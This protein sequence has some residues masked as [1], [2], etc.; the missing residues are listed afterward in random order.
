MSNAPRAAPHCG[1]K[2]GKK[3]APG[4]N[5]DAMR[6]AIA[7]AMAR[8]K[9]EIPHYYLAHDVDVTAS[10]HWLT[11]TNA[12]RLPENRLLMGA[13]ALKAVALA[14]RRY[15][16]F[17]G[18]YRDNK[19]EP[20]PAVHVGV[21]VSIRGGGLAAPALH[22]VD[23]TPLDDL[24]AHMRD[25][26]QRTRA[27]CIRSSE[28]SDA[29]ITVSSLGERGVDALRHHLSAAG[30]D[31]RC[32]QGGGAAL[33]R[34]RRHRA[35]LDCYPHAVGGS[36][37]QRR[38]RGG[39]NSGRDRQAVA[40]A[41]KAMSDID[42]MKV[43]QEEL[44]NIAPEADLTT[45]DPTADLR[46]ALDV[47]SMD[48]LNFIAAIHH[49]LGIDIPEIDYPKLGTLDGAVAYLTAHRKPSRSDKM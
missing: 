29:T 13:L 3:R 18:F 32:W 42:I 34:G 49:R 41:G 36:P 10:E 21:A 31:R 7:A 5:L 15:P 19:F 22:D 26:V 33:G 38:S 6:V 48:F 23:Q 28:L 20:A 25:L 39:A 24:M 40:G 30:G 37:R 43:V 16:A 2:G 12:T 27:G 17:N 45:V 11:E 46:E 35:A 8:S 9:L 44:N 1:G 4:L 14:A 47:D